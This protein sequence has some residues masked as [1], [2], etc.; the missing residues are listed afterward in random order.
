MKNGVGREFYSSEIFYRTKKESTWEFI[1]SQQ[2]YHREISPR[3]QRNSPVVLHLTI[4][5]LDGVHSPSFPPKCNFMNEY[6]IL[7][8]RSTIE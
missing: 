4:I 1:T 3:I 2:T 6:D 8:H 7:C 5:H